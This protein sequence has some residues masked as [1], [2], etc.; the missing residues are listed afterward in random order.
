VADLTVEDVVKIDDSTVFAL[1]TGTWNTGAP[2]RNMEQIV[3]A[4]SKVMEVE[5]FFGLPRR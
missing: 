3:L 1:Y 4:E 5:V 2:F